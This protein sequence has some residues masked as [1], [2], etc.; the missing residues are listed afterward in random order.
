MN[1]FNNI[2]ARHDNYNIYGMMTSMIN[3]SVTMMHN[4]LADASIGMHVQSSS[5]L[6]SF[7]ILFSNGI[8]SGH[9]E[10]GISSSGPLTLLIS[11]T[12][13]FNNLADGVTGSNPL[14]GDPKYKSPISYNY[15]LNRGSQ[16]ID[17]IASGFGLDIDGDTRPFGSSGTPFDAGADEFIHSVFFFLPLSLR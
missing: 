11:D 3:T 12:L 1:L 17:R 14:T 16:A 8:V 10:T 2:I 15:H 13:F 6:G 5:G 4:T 9:T 7:T